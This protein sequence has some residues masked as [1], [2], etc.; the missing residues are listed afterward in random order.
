MQHVGIG[1]ASLIT[2]SLWA[3]AALTNPIG[4][5]VLTLGVFAWVAYHESR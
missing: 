2:S 1:T 4:L 3:A 5:S